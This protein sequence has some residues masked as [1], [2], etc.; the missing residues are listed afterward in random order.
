LGVGGWG[1]VSVRPIQNKKNKKKIKKG[2]S[3]VRTLQMTK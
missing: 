1:W 3:S 2:S